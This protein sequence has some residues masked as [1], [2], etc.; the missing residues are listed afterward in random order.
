[1]HV[2]EEIQVLHAHTTFS[3]SKRAATDCYFAQANLVY[4]ACEV[5]SMEGF[6]QEKDDLRRM[7]QSL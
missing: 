7:K 1:M 4:G 3:C 6:D 5:P 2:S